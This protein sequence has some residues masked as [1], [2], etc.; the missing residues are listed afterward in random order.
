MPKVSVVMPAYNAENYIAQAIDSILAQSFRDFE[1]LILNDC[2]TDGTEALICAYNDPRIVYLKNDKNM[3]VAA[4]LNK[5]LAAAKGEYIARMDADDIS[6]PERFEKQV[7]YLDAHPDV[8]VLGTHVECFSSQGSGPLVQYRGSP[9]QMRIDL[10]F[11][12]ALAHPSVMLRRQPILELGG[13]DSSYEG[14]EDYE[15]WCR[16]AEISDL[17]VLPQV[18]LRYRL[19][20][21]QVTQQ[22]SERKR[23]AARKLKSRLLAQL[24]LATEG[25]IAEAYY[26]YQTKEKKSPDQALA[27]IRFFEALLEA[28]RKKGLYDHALLKKLMHQLAKSNA[29]QLAPQ[30]QRKLCRQTRLLWY[31]QLLLSR[32]KQTLKR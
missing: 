7:A 12:S 19:H 4:T 25:P 9:A 11:S 6:L 23:L 17:A 28:N 32:L 2:S 1:F 14:M 26:G 31:P 10:L 13:Y 21:A 20:P 5:G 16:V 8:T 27:E 22:P 18:L 3:G 15:L 24:E 29:V 30:A